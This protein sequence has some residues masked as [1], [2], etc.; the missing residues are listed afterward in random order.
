MRLF[1]LRGDD[2]NALHFHHLASDTLRPCGQH[3]SDPY[4]YH[5]LPH[6]SIVGVLRNSS[7]ASRGQPT[8]EPVNPSHPSMLHYWSIVAAHEKGIFVYHMKKEGKG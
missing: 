8:V 5:T 1:F 6:M 7:H 2:D 3:S 4:G